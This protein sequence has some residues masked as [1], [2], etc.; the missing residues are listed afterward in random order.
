MSREMCAQCAK[1][2]Q[3]ARGDVFG[4][5]EVW[6]EGEMVVYGAHGR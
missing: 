4:G 6:G 1:E 5:G 3:H 2:A